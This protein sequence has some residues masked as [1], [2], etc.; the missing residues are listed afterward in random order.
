MERNQMKNIVVLKN[1]PSNLVEEA[2]VILKSNKVAESLRYIDKREVAV[3]KENNSKSKDYI[4]REAEMIISNYLS[5]AQKEE[6]KKEKDKIG[7][8]YKWIR[9]YSI[10]VTVMFV[11]G[12]IF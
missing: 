7:M 4:I 1:L 12:L 2:F 8:K 9:I 6:K 10:V 11:I 5:S 3:N